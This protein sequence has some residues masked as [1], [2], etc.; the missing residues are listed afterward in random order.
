MKDRGL[1]KEGL[2]ADLVVFDPETVID[3]STWEDPHQYASGIPYVLV[4][5]TPVIDEGV[6]TQARPGKVLRRGQS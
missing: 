2:T 4:K 1:L 5:G 6:H 3:N